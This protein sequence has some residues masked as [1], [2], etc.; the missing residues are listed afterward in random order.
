MPR[1]SE[2]TFTG[3][4]F[5]SGTM[6]GVSNVPIWPF[7][8]SR[9]T[10]LTEKRPGGSVTPVWYSTCLAARPSALAGG[11]VSVSRIRPTGNPRSSRM[12]PAT[13]S[14]TLSLD[15]GTADPGTAREI[16]T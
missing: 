4:C 7:A 6:S 13:S 15:G 12:K 1:T 5:N 8:F 2:L 10:I 16:G 3:A 11:T 14:V 9:T